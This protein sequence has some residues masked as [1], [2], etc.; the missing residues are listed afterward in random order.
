MSFDLAFLNGTNVNRAFLKLYLLQNSGNA[1]VTVGTASLS[2][3]WLEKQ[4]NWQQAKGGLLWASPGAAG[5]DDYQN[6]S[7]NLFNQQ[8]IQATSQWYYFEVTDQIKCYLA[9]PASFQGFLLLPTG[10]NSASTVL[11]FA[12][13]EYPSAGFRPVLEINYQPQ[14]ASVSPTLMPTPT[15]FVNP[16]PTASVSPTPTATST[17]TPT[18]TPT[19]SPILR[20][21]NPESTVSRQYHQDSSTLASPPLFWDVDF[22]RSFSLAKAARLEEI[23]IKVK[24]YGGGQKTV[25]IAITTSANRRVEN[26]LP[27]PLIWQGTAAI[28]CC[29]HEGWVSLDLSQ[30]N[31][32][33]DSSTDYYVWVM[34]NNG[35]RAI[36]WFRGSLLITGRT[37]VGSGRLPTAT[38]AVSFTPSPTSTPSGFACTPLSTLEKAAA[39]ELG[40]NPN[41]LPDDWSTSFRRIIKPVFAGQGG[42]LKIYLHNW[43]QAG[44]TVN[45][46]LLYTSPSP[47]DRTRSRMPSSA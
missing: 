41:T 35:Y 40:N 47:R 11:S 12:S 6:S 46:C 19:E 29:Y 17:S 8:R 22:G 18:P 32:V 20:E 15:V 4:V 23:R 28:P 9:N 3:S 38:P 33:L 44:K 36:S 24:N 10:M 27:A 1:S 13:R 42:R 2:K 39:Y 30:K 34:D 16:T 25:A 7:L 43:G 31:V 45:Y 37:C 14:S 26:S 5:A 21:C